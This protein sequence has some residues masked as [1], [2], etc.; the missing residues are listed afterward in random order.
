VSAAP[1][2]FW[3][4]SRAAGMAAMWLSSV[5]VAVGLWMGTGNARTRRS[6]LRALHEALSLSTLAAIA[7]HGVSLLF[8]SFFQPG[9]AGIAVP[10]AGAYRSTWT[11]I[12]IIAGY[13]LAVLGLTYYARDRLGAAAWRAAH[14]FTALFWAL[15]IAHAIGAGTDR[16]TLWFLAVL[17]A[18]GVPAAALL[19]LR[20]GR[21]LAGYLDLPRTA[22]PV[23]LSERR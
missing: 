15:G 21:G 11:G 20:L 10:F 12:G 19:C 6:E 2:L 8:D 13:G 16:A 1:H 23:Q 22:P 7:V 5:S 9:I 4:T 3:I 18:T 14:R 17:L